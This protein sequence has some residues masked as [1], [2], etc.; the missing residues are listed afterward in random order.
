MEIVILIVLTIFFVIS[1]T[2]ITA[3]LKNINN[4]LINIQITLEELLTPIK[5]N[6]SGTTS[7]LRELRGISN[8]VDDLRRKI[9][10]TNEEIEASGIV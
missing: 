9:A 8:D 3:S 7:K 6:T 5:E 4:N 2:S 1:L 10:P